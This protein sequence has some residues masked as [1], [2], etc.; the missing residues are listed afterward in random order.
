[1]R[2]CVERGR[3][4][5]SA[6]ARGEVDSDSGGLRRSAHRR[7]HSAKRRSRH[8]SCAPGLLCDDVSSG[9]V[10]ARE[11]RSP[12]E[13]AAQR[14]PGEDRAFGT[15][16]ASPS[17]ERGPARARSTRTTPSTEQ[18][19]RL[20]TWFNCNGCHFKAAAAP[21]RPSWTTAGSTAAHREHRPD[22]PGRAAERHAVVQR[23]GSRRPDLGAC[24]LCPFDERAGLQA[25]APSRN[26][27]MHPHPSENRMP[28]PNP[29][30]GAGPSRPP[31]AAIERR[32]ASSRRSV[33]PFLPL[34]GCRAG[35]RRSTRTGPKP[36]LDILF[37]T[38][39]AI[40]GP[41]GCA[42]WSPSSLRC[43]PAGPDADPLARTAS[44]AARTVTSPSSSASR[45]HRARA[46]GLSYAGQRAFSHKDGA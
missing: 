19:K 45:R 43:E 9:S 36:S 22:D 6:T 31:A 28:P 11:T 10:R 3:R 46:H 40:L 17:D 12:P 15:R 1:M 38:F 16:R 44:A 5:A 23:Q 14:N 18:G 4:R 2:G 30:A 29:V 13:P 41:S 24:G 39:T 27:D 33:L 25:A 37:W 20:Y 32:H 34:A 8:E 26:D 42:T 21:A 35:N 7:A